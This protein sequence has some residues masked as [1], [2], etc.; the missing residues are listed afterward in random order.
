M[1][2]FVVPKDKMM[3]ILK[4]SVVKNL[5][6]EMKKKGI[7]GWRFVDME[8]NEDGVIVYM[9]LPSTGPQSK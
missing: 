5:E 9:D 4:E 7:T 3:P 1:Q 6:K 2:R 8:W